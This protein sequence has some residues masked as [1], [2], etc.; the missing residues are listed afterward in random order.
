A[1]VRYAAVMVALI[2]ALYV[3]QAIKEMAIEKQALK[4]SSAV[5]SRQASTQQGEQM[6]LDLSYGVKIVLNSASDLRYV[7]RP[8]GSRDVYLKGE[9][10]FDVV[11]STSRTFTVHVNDETIRDV[12][13][14][15]NVRA[16]PD[17]KNMWVSVMD[18]SV[19]IQRDLSVG[20]DVVVSRNQY[21]ILNGAGIVVPPTYT[22]VSRDI[23]WMEG[24]L[25][26]HNAS[27]G[28]VAKQLYWN[29][30]I[31]CLV[32]D[33]SILSRR[34]TTAF[35]KQDPPKR[36]ISIIAL[37]LNLSCEV[38]GDSV[39]FVDSKTAHPGR[40]LPGQPYEKQ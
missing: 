10:Y 2:G 39:L 19:S 11:H 29:Y 32:A 7:E 40:A 3:V 13:T 5:I 14:R 33:T 9:A 30:G 1:V 22:D 37:T 28:E 34:I 27:M 15:F 16:W 18:G 21:C 20:T 38:S 36:I 26:F 24:K 31:R 23:D 8:D 6:T 35:D 17:D 12:G 25:V 4:R